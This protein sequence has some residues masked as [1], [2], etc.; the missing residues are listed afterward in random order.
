MLAEPVR[1]APRRHLL[2]DNV[3]QLEVEPARDD[4]GDLCQRGVLN[5][6]D[7]PVG[8][9]AAVAIDDV[10]HARFF[11]AQHGGEQADRPVQIL[12]VL[13]HDRDAVGMAILDEHAAVAIEDEAAR[14]T[15]R[16][17]ALMVV[18]GHLLVLRVL[19]DL[20]HPEADRQHREHHHDDVLQHREANRQLPAI[21][22]QSHFIFA[23][24][25]VAPCA[26]PSLQ[27]EARPPETR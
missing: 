12:R 22:N 17:R 15:Q 11:D 3:W 2:D 25:C 21:F 14:R 16:E 20:Q 10:A 26:A 19:D 18:L 1:V 27:V 13:A 23:A 9:L 4:G 5:D 7:R 6:C 8:R 24:G